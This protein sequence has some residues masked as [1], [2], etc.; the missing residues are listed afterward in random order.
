MKSP[1][2][3]TLP[4]LRI[5]LKFTVLLPELLVTVVLKELPRATTEV[6]RVIATARFSLLVARA[7]G[8]NEEAVPC[9]LVYTTEDIPAVG[10]E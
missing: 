2:A 8:L 9:S 1:P 6:P 3:G 5:S 7:L 10:H 4:G